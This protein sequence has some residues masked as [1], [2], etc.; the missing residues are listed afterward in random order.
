VYVIFTVASAVGV[1]TD[2][3]IGAFDLHDLVAMTLSVDYHTPHAA[4]LVASLAHC[5]KERDHAKEADVTSICTSSAYAELVV[6]VVLQ[7]LHSGGAH[8]E[9]G[10]GGG[11]TGGGPNVGAGAPGQRTSIVNTPTSVAPSVCS[12]LKRRGV[13]E[14]TVLPLSE[15]DVLYLEQG[16][17]RSR[18]DEASIPPPPSG[19]AATLS[20]KAGFGVRS[21]MG[22]IV[23]TTGQTA[24]AGQ[25][26]NAVGNILEVTVK[27][28]YDLDNVVGHQMLSLSELTVDPQSPRSSNRGSGGAYARS[29]SLNRV[30]SAAGSDMQDGSTHSGAMNADSAHGDAHSKVT[31]SK[32][33][34][35]SMFGLLRGHK[36]TNTDAAN[37]AS[38]PVGRK[39]APPALSTNSSTENLDLAQT[40]TGAQ[41]RRTLPGLSRPRCASF[42]DPLFCD[43]ELTLRANLKAARLVI[44]HAS[45]LPSSSTALAAKG[46]PPT[47]YATVYL[48]DAKG[49]KRS[50]NSVDSRTEAIKS[51]D[52]Q[53]NKEVLLQNER[54][55]VDDITSVMILFRDSAMGYVKHHHIGR[56]MIPFSCFLDNTQ[57][58]FCLPLE[59]TYRYDS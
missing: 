50:V 34:A 26:S 53:W 15:E 11:S 42:H 9:N 41:G 5:E 16:E 27:D 33:P 56:V 46:I 20:P 58:D 18:S 35:S 38:N 3:V 17:G 1:V 12:T 10:A 24:G 29:I 7:R 36:N 8:A 48:V 31:P 43:I 2:T 28:R 47:V 37:G 57:A 51:F 25:A 4:V 54:Q 21:F 59:P 13:G 52:P 40:P 39:T 23:G 22:P 14:V 45:S 49:E 32:S 30:G 44:K 55:G 19:A 6:D